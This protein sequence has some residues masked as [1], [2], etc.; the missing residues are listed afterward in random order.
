MRSKFIYFDLLTFY[1][2]W[3]REVIK[4]SKAPE[5]IDLSQTGLPTFQLESKVLAAWLG[6]SLLAELVIVGGN[7][8]SRRSAHLLDQEKPIRFLK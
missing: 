3:R 1:D 6:T 2:F 5:D 7:L 8:Y 4:L